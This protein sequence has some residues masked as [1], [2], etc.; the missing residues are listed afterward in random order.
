MKTTPN[1]QLAIDI[2]DRNVLVSAA[3]GSGKT[4]VLVERIISR[5][6]G[7]DGIDIDRIL[8]M[9]FTNAAAAEIRSRIRDA[10]DERLSFLRET[11]DADPELIANL[12]KQSLLVHSAMIT[13]IHGFCKSVITDHFEELGI[14]PN[15]RVA[16]E[17]ECKLMQQDAL[18][19][20]MVEAYE[21]GD[22]AFLRAV[23]C[24]SAAKNDKGIAELVIPIHRF[25]MADPDPEAFLKKCC[26]SYDY[27]DLDD[28]IE[29]ETAENVFGYVQNEYDKIKFLIDQASTILD[30]ND[31]LE[32]YRANIKAFQN[33]IKD[34]DDK[35]E[36]AGDEPPFDI[37]R[38]G[39]GAI[40]PP[41]FG[42]IK[43]EGLGDDE[44]E[45]KSAVALL[46]DAAKK[47]IAGLLQAFPF[48]LNVAFGHMLLAKDELGA[49]AGLVAEFSRIYE[50]IKRDNN[51]IDFADMEH[52]AVKVL[53]NPDIA[54]VY[55]EQ[56]VEIYVD[57]YQDTNMAQEQLVRLIC[58]HEPGNVF[59]VG[60]VKQSIYRFRQARPDIFLE[61]YN[62][63]TDED[64]ENRRILL[65]DNF[66]SRQTVVDAVN[67]VFAK[68]MTAEFGGIE[69]DES[70]ALSYGATCYKND[71]PC[72]GDSYKAELLI[73]VKGELESEELTANIIAGRINSM[74][75]EGFLIYDKKEEVIRPVSY[76]DF[77]ILVRSIKKYEPAFRTVFNTVGIPLCVNG[78]EGYFGTLEVR[79]ALSFL[80]A[81]DNSYCDIELATLL[82][83]PVGGFDDKDL[84]YLAAMKGEKLCL[85]D[86]IKLAGQEIDGTGEKEETKEK[87]KTGIPE[88]LR[89]KCKHM[90]ELLDRYKVMST[91]TPV[92][93]VL[94]H[95]IDNEYSDYVK[96]MTNAPQR[97]ANLRML[98]SKAEEYGRTSFKGLYGFV[99]YMDQ[100]QKYNIDDGEASSTGENDDVVRIM[101]MHASKGLEFPVCFI[102]GLEKR[103][104]I[105]DET[106]KLIWG[107]NYG[108]GV[109]FTDVDRRITGTTL[110]KVLVKTD[111]K[112]ESIAEEM[113]LL[114][115]AMTRA[116][117][118]LIMVAVDKEDAFEKPDKT[119]EN[120]LSY[121]DMIKAA[122]GFAGFEH[123]DIGYKN[124]TDLVSLRLEKK[125][126]EESAADDLYEVINSYA[127]PENEDDTES[128]TE[129]G[130]EPNLLI[131]AE[132]PYPINPELRPKLSVSDLKHK[133]I[134]EKRAAGEELAPE[135]ELL[136][137]ETEPDRYI[138]KFMR[139]EGETKTGATF[140]GTAFHRIM[141]LWDYDLPV[142]ADIITTF[143]NKMH[144][145]HRMDKD[146]VN[147][148]NPSD[149]K[150]FLESALAR[151]MAD[152]NRNKKLFREQPFVIGVPEDGEMILVQGI[153]DAYFIE[154][155][156]ITIVDYKTDRVSNDKMLVD[157]YQTQLE[158]YGKALSQIT[159]LPIKALTI[160]ST[161]LKREI[162]I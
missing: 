91:N 85:Y 37:I 74:I 59:Q 136:F 42:S 9:T 64:E 157:R 112:R 147:A 108:F 89:E 152:A 31:F 101:T 117:E 56:F 65:N 39:L 119:V 107:T 121:L 128:E 67:E 84:A 110:P 140:Y 125:L 52:M 141:E 63:Y 139:Q 3:A 66:R 144:D 21:K 92:R 145:L 98:L 40:D 19:E 132:Y 137:A 105:Q 32:P 123:I 150:T 86:R 73:G 109:D 13:T 30:Q 35:L 75:S 18:D 51:V 111:N 116:R 68:I 22:E 93:N 158:Y 82:R 16:D 131:G 27:D 28:F 79:T 115:V 43:E 90:L 72:E 146:Q 33:G 100:I 26:Q 153:I 130:T 96:C 2:R 78:S 25:I 8:T 48:D 29:S 12:E 61:K 161:C 36:E 44:L 113:R 62:T 34:I 122:H 133:A 129:T 15:F 135:G 95:F 70:A 104:N 97:M 11:K 155:D 159:G 102:A 149:V 7:E 103:R 58:R 87:E 49:L 83:S 148:V 127:E 120:A 154:E 80:A 55:R 54:A 4:S 5:V 41:R 38:H 118:K 106:G 81:V 94:Q 114:Y 50:R 134:E 77:T 45:A 14:D 60:D 126:E 71:A 46:R 53:S 24:F 69:Y 76:R 57:E 88:E 10:I 162:V 99:R 23:E 143:A 151:R 1:Q 160:Y 124:E 156:G 142:S 138:P 17:N 6:M 20:C 47:K